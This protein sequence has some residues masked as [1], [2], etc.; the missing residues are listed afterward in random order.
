[1]MTN[2]YTQFDVFNFEITWKSI[3]IPARLQLHTYKNWSKCS[4]EMLGVTPW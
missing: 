1:M 3:S 2:F 4:K